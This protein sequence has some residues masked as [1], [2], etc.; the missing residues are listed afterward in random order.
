MS[1]NDVDFII[2]SWQERGLELFEVDGDGNESWK[3]LCVVDMFGGPTL[4]C[5]WL[6]FEWLQERQITYVYMKE[7]EEAG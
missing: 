5:S 3:D 4:P 6:E 2:T 1:P 7:S